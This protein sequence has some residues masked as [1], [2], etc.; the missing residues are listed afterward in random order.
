[1]AFAVPND[2]LSGIL[3][4]EG[5][6]AIRTEISAYRISDI[7]CGMHNIRT[8]KIRQTFTL[9]ENVFRRFV[10]LVPEGQRSAIISTLLEAEIA[11]REKNLIHA[12]DAVNKNNELATLESDFQDLE[13]TIAEAW[14]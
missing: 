8:Y 9:P 7:V 14:D 13:D 5:F 10:N 12:C 3:A 11:R 6:E 4:Y 2:L 1:L